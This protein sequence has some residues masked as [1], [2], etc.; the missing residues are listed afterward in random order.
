[1]HSIRCP[2]FALA[3]FVSFFATPLE[4][5]RAQGLDI[6]EADVIDLTHA[7]DTDTIFWPTETEGF[8]LTKIFRGPTKEGFFYAAYKFCLPEHGGTHL[9][10]PFHFAERGWTTAKIPLKRLIGSGQQET[11]REDSEMGSSRKE[12]RKHG[13]SRWRR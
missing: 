3:L 4:S 2:L 6:A 8:K 10:A 5:P 11:R 1:M 12:V 9:D 7:F 13:Y